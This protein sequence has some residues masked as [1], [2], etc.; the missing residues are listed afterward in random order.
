M[1]VVSGAMQQFDNKNEVGKAV[2][3]TG[4]SRH[5]VGPAK[6]IKQRPG[7]DTSSIERPQI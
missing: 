3:N 1:K 5:V 4:Y 2:A 7:T 6:N